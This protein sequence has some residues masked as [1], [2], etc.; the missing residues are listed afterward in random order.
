MQNLL[1]ER[2]QRGLPAIGGWLTIPSPVV[3]EAMAMT[4]LDW[5]AVDMEH[6]PYA[7][8][9]MQGVFLA[10]KSRGVTP[11]VR[12]PSADPYLARRMLDA[13]SAGIIVPVV[14]DAETFGTFSQH[15]LFPPAG[16][17]GIGLSRC[18]DWGDRFEDYLETFEPVIVPQIETAAGVEA[19]PSIAARGEVDALFL[20]P[21][22][23]SASLGHRGDFA[24]PMFADAVATVREACE[25]HGK[26]AGIHQVE[27]DPKALE[28]RV[29]EGF[30]FVAYGT[31]MIA[32]RAAMSVPEISK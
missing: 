2:L 23:L 14:E 6:A 30:R 10:L 32:M 16:R 4:G 20:G 5:I 15:C 3:A 17:R 25:V 13:G 18:N 28:A 19:S 9:E 12:L 24:T 11:L 31:D 29:K 22:D 27:P 21:Y 7:E 26:A 8:G 1:K